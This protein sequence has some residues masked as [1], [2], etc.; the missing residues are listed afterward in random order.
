MAIAGGDVNSWDGPLAVSVT[1][2]GQVT[3][4]GP[5]CRGGAR[6]GDQIVVT[7]AFGGSILGRHFDFEPR[8]VEALLLSDRYELHAGIDASDGLVIDLSHVAA[9]S[10]CG[11]V[12]Q[13]D[14]VPIS[15]GRPAAGRPTRPRAPRRWSTPWATARI[16]S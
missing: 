3:G 11:A 15:R 8:V 2:L 13:T 12:L 1:L 5:L 10:G 14:A 9:E 4:R 7:G 16:S 6:P